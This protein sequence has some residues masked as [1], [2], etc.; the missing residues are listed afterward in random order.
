[1]V[2]VT[3][4]TQKNLKNWNSETFDTVQ[5]QKVSFSGFQFLNSPSEDI[6]KINHQKNTAGAHANPQNLIRE[7]SVGV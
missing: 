2:F 6:H 1:M 4:I 3:Y 7:I 5:K